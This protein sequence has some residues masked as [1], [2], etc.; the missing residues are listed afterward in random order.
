M[1]SESFSDVGYQ[2]FSQTKNTEAQSSVKN[3]IKKEKRETFRD[4]F[5]KKFNNTSRYAIHTV[6]VLAVLSIVVLGKISSS[7]AV[8]TMGMGSVAS[9]SDQKSMI[10][11]GAILANSAQSV[12][13]EDVSQR[14]KDISNLGTLTTTADSFLQN[15]SQVL[16]AGAPSRDIL[17]YKV[18]QGDTLATISAKFNITTDTI[19]WANDISSDADLNQGKEITILPVSGIMHTVQEG[20]DTLALAN[21][22]QSNASLIESFNGL[23]GKAPAVGSK[24]VIPDGV[25]PAPS[26]PAPNNSNSSSGS[27]ASSNDYFSNTS[28]SGLANTYYW[29]QCTWYVASRRPIP[30]NWGNAI[31]WYYNAQRAGF[32]TGSTPRV[33]AVGWERNNHVVYVESVNSDGTVTISEMNWGGRPGVLHYRTTPASQFLYIY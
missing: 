21:R 15:K 14:A 16:S 13:A 19:K 27:G 6:A 8:N 9:K 24:I 10:T 12:I 26:L 5:G 1:R 22:Y 28:F 32:G 4:L 3:E 31:S 18:K 25:K 20:D 11:T 33:G 29:G 30:N 7:E 17:A 23:E 2:N